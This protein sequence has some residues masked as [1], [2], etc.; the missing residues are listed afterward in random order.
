MK[1]I[2]ISVKTFHPTFC[3]VFANDDDATQEVCSSSSPILMLAKS[4]CL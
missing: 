4:S 1:Y 3:D 2:Y